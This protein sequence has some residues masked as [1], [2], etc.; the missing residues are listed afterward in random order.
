MVFSVAVM[1]HLLECHREGLD[2]YS[3]CQTTYST[4]NRLETTYLSQIMP[5]AT[6]PV[7]ER[8]GPE[9]GVESEAVLESISI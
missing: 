6:Y 1:K 9:T 3:D 7:C 8:T 2:L 5:T 4:K